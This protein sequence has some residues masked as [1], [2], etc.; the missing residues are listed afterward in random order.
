MLYY[1]IF[2]LGVSKYAVSGS[3]KVGVEYLGEFGFISSICFCEV[4]KSKLTASFD[5]ATPSE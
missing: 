3:I 1:Y 4:S 5:F 2:Y